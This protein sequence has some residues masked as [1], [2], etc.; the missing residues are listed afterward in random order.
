MQINANLSYTFEHAEEIISLTAW[1][2][3]CIL[4]EKQQEM[5]KDCI[6]G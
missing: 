5:T 1:K 3:L 4:L 2:P 6:A